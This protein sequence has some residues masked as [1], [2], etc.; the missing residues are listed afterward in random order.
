[1]VNYS[2]RSK[3]KRSKHKRKRS[4]KSVRKRNKSVR[5][6]KHSI[7]KPKKYT[8]GQSS[9]QLKVSYGSVVIAGQD[10]TGQAAIYNLPPTL[11]LINADPTKTYLIKMTDPDAPGG[12]YTHYVVKYTG[13]KSTPT[14]AYRPPTP[15]KGTG[16]HHYMFHIYLDGIA[17]N[18]LLPL[19]PPIQFTVKN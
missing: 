18:P 12:T 13:G 9:L 2:R 8:G 14:T 11:T 4:N 3:H 15:P 7:R 10:L 5:K 17:K 19:L 1:M 6:H 16:I